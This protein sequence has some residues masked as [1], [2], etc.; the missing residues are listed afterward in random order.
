MDIDRLDALE[1]SDLN[2]ERQLL[3]RRLRD[4]NRPCRWVP[5]GHL[6]WPVVD[7]LRSFGA[8][9]C[10]DDGATYLDAGGF[11]PRGLGTP[12]L[13]R[14]YVEGGFG[15]SLSRS[16]FD[17][18]ATGAYL[19]DLGEAFG[20]RAV[21]GKPLGSVAKVAGE[22]FDADA[23]AWV[24]VAS[25]EEG[26]DG[27]KFVSEEAFAVLH[28]RAKSEGWKLLRDERWRSAR[29]LLPE[30]LKVADCDALLLE[31]AV[32]FAEGEHDEV[33]E[34][35]LTA[36][37]AHRRRFAL[38]RRRELSDAAVA[39]GLEEKL[40]ALAGRFSV[41]RGVR[42]GIR[43]AALELP[44]ELH[45]R[46]ALAQLP[47]RGVLLEG[48]GRWLRF[49]IGFDWDARAIDHLFDALRGTL[50]WLEANLNEAGEGPK[51]TLENLH[52]PQKMKRPR[53][54]YEVRVR[55]VEEAETEAVLDAVVDLEARVYEPER[56]DPREKL[57]LAFYDPAGVAVIA[58]LRPE[59]NE[60][61]PWLV[62]G[63]GLAAPLE[64]V[65]GVDGCETDAM[66]GKG[67]TIYAL[68]TTL[69][70]DYRG[71]G[72][73]FA[74]KQKMIEG[75]SKLRRED[76]SPRYHWFS[77]RMRVGATAAMMH[78]NAQLGAAEVERLEKQYGSDAQATYYRQPVDLLMVEPSMRSPAPASTRLDVRSGA[79][80]QAPRTWTQLEAAGGLFGA[81]TTPLR[82]VESI[83]GQRAIRYLL[84]NT[85]FDRVCKLRPGRFPGAVPYWQWQPVLGR[86]VLYVDAF[87]ATPQMMASI[88]AEIQGV[89][90]DFA[91]Q[92]LFLSRDEVDDDHDVLWDDLPVLEL[93]HR[94][95]RYR[96]VDTDWLG[97]FEKRLPEA[98]R[99]RQR[100]D[101]RWLLWVGEKMPVFRRELEQRGLQLGFWD[102]STLLLA[103]PIDLD[104]DARGA[105]GDAL[106]AAIRA[107][108]EEG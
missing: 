77:G 57:G 23:G 67:N 15:T 1:E 54:A 38:R 7:R 92:S 45:V 25:V 53:P 42:R 33:S 17:E 11:A 75:A 34:T 31:D 79:R 4:T 95:R 19:E 41:L 40:N 96:G 107:A 105:L 106:D 16:D 48:Q 93:Q 101:H 6:R 84:A 86:A 108:M 18:Q 58:E 104:A 89:R 35:K 39:D 29:G 85:P 68:A 71:L 30:G 76:G 82:G 80:G 83:E 103:P 56:R 44:T 22:A 9:V 59:G 51:P 3:Q 78:I 52:R 28:R 37:Q 88:S 20:G 10:G 99:Y 47:A 62:V 32:V 73:G 66:R 100:V 81:A 21:L 50:K 55:V 69:D 102:G 13:S 8:W 46:A 24:C 49:G 27:P 5:A 70:P 91:G 63:A 65:H 12:V 94:W 87:E 36:A 2:G 61:A 74:V 98:D 14:A 97:F 64:R 26:D 72:L 90:L 60:A 43:E